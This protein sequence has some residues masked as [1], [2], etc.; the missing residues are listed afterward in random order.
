MIEAGLGKQNTA[1]QVWIFGTVDNS[2]FDITW[3]EEKDDVWM[4][5]DGPFF[6][7]RHVHLIRA[8]LAHLAPL[9]ALHGFMRIPCGVNV[10]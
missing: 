5:F 8:S 1:L 7:C 9:D 2:Q 4:P 3:E 6:M 10:S